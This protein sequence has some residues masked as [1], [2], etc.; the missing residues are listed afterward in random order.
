MNNC[1]KLLAMHFE[2]EAVNSSDHGTD[3]T[4]NIHCFQSKS[5]RHCSN[6]MTE[7]KAGYLIY[8]QLG[9]KE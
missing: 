8:I 2:N 5:E 3:Q 4:L 6:C 1:H 9:E 7:I